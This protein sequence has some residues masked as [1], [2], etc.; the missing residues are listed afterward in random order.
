M[1]S[2]SDEQQIRDVISTW[3]DATA[4]G[5]LS[6]VLSLMA[7]DVVFLLPG[8]EPMRG[9]KAFADA[10]KSGGPPPKIQAKSDI[11]EIV[12]S[13]SYAWCWTHLAITMP[14]ADGSPPVQ[15]AGHTLSIFRKEP[16]GRWLL[17]RD[18]NLLAKL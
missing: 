7:E 11:R 8:R 9:R 14:P 16:D 3:M 13:G 1:S 6:Q 2:T 18:A 17:F 5:D 12:V 10:S 4:R 15:R